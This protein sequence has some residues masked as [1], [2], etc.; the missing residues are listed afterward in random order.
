MAHLCKRSIDS[1]AIENIMSFFTWYRP[2]VYSF[3]ALDDKSYV[4]L[5]LETVQFYVAT[6]FDPILCYTDT[7]IS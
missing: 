6:Y 1:T 4:P 5:M 2:G 3:M 7:G